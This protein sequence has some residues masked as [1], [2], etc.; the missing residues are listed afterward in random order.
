MRFL[1]RYERKQ[2]RTALTLLFNVVLL[3]G[4]YAAARLL[5]EPTDATEQLF[6]WMN[7]AVPVVA[8]GLLGMAARLWIQNEAFR[9]SITADRFEIV[10]PLFPSTSFSVPVD[11]ILEIR[12]THSAPTGIST[13]KMHMQSGESIQLLKNYNYSRTKLYAAL[14]EANPDIRLPQSAHRFKSV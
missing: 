2:R 6:F 12:Q 11:E 3:F 1:Y 13:I 5:L 7:L 9:I 8:L 14:A 4:M 10:D